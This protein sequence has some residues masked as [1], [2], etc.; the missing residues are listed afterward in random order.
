MTLKLPPQH[1][2]HLAMYRR[3]QEAARTGEVTNVPEFNDMS[4]Y[5]HVSNFMTQARVTGNFRHGLRV[6]R[7]DIISIKQ[8]PEEEEDRTGTLLL[9]TGAKISR[10]GE[11]AA[12][13]DAMLAAA[14][15]GYA[16]WPR[17]CGHLAEHNWNKRNADYPFLRK[18][19]KIYYEG[20]M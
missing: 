4:G 20:E 18:N 3:L 19:G 15:N 12:E 5:Q 13:V 6:N 17:P 2:R 14:K 8:P 16:D 9:N 1:A 11:L 7:N 10:S